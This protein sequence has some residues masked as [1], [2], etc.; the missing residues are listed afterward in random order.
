[1][2]ANLAQTQRLL[3]ALLRAPKGAAAGIATLSPADQA[4]AA[5]LVRPREPLAAVERLDI[6]A[7]MYFFR[8]LDALRLDFPAVAAVL[9]DTGFHNRVT[10]YLLVHPS[11]HYS[12]RYVG[13]HLPDFLRHPR[14]T[15]E[16]A[17]LADLAAFE[18]ALLDSFDAPDAAPLQAAELAAIAAESWPGLRLGLSSSLRLVAA[19][20]PLDAIWAGAKAGDSMDHMD[21]MDS[22]RSEARWYR[23]WRRD[24]RVFHRGISGGEFA[25]LRALESGATFAEV[26]DQVEADSVDSAA[27]QVFDWI[28][29]WLGDALLT[30]PA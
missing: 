25:A 4:L 17:W 26:C 18:W 10:D 13:R 15:D 30:C 9:G 16:P 22:L 24:L 21:S 3:W 8:L 11:T 5:Q 14:T 2:T 20:A 6:Y 29:T 28:R 12:L 1:M 7:N 19:Y 23:I 27:G